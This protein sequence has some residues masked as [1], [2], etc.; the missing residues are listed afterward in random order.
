MVDMRYKKG[1]LCFTDCSNKCREEIAQLIMDT[2]EEH[3]IPLS[4]SRVQAYDNAAN[5]VGQYNASQ[6]KILVQ[7]SMAIFSPHV[8]AILSICVEM[9]QP[10]AYWK[11]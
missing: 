7:C 3:A 5:M 6:T 11:P 9:M 8:A 2:L 10:S 4:N 1:F